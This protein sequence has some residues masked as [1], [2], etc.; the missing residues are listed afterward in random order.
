MYAHLNN[1]KQYKCIDDES[2]SQWTNGDVIVRSCVWHL[3]LYGEKEKKAAHSTF[4]VY[5]LCVPDVDMKLTEILLLVPH[6]Q[7]QS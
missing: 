2:L 3:C 1:T 4:Y 5:L 7:L 6:W